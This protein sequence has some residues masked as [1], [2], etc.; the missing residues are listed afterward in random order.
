[1]SLNAAAAAL[2]LA[3]LALAG[4]ANGGPGGTVEVEVGPGHVVEF[5]EPPKPSHGIVS[6]IVG[7]DALYPLPEAT[8]IV[9]GMGLTGVSDKNGRFAIL[10]VPTGLYILE[11]RK[12]DHETVQ[13][14]VDVQ[15]GEIARAVLLLGRLPPTDPYHT[16]VQQDAFVEFAAPLFGA[17]GRNTTLEFSR[18][19]SRAVTLV[20]ESTWEGTIQSTVDKP[21]TYTLEERDLRVIVTDAAANPFVLHL[22]ARILPPEQDAFR[23]TVEPRWSDP[24]VMVQARG[25]VFATLFYNAPA[26]PGWSILAGNV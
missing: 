19:P 22:D 26:P 11:G 18:D 1:M 23:L 3:A 10:D 15:P 12:K 4:C 13:T 6:G 2:L 14:T 21:L 20:A 7:D 9:V 5:E 16:T 24:V 8:V 17:I 25:Q